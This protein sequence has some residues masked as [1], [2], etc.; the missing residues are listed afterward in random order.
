VH[1]T[2]FPH[3]CPAAPGEARATEH[4]INATLRE[5][6]NV[7]YLITGLIIA[8]SV[9]IWSYINSSERKVERWRSNV[10]VNSAM[11]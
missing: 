8:T 4:S 3:A 2:S 9:L 6:R 5:N 1:L 7:L 11:V 10:S